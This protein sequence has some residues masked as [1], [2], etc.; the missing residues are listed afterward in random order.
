[1]RSSVTF[2]IFIY[3]TFNYAHD[4]TI[5]IT[6]PLSRLL[7]RFLCRCLGGVLTKIVDNQ[8][9]ISHI[10]LLF[11]SVNHHNYLERQVC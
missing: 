10:E 9:V 8:F 4:D 2:Y 1:M 11:K 3:I 6:Q 5:F 7:Q